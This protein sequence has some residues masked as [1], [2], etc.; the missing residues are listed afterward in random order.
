MYRFVNNNDIVPRVPFAVMW[1]R[2]AGSLYYIN[3]YGN[4]RSATVWQRLKDRLRGYWNAWKK[5]M[6]FDSI[7]DHAMPKYIKRIH[8]FAYYDDEMKSK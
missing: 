6:W 3:T 4:I 7:Y 8:D 1:Y 2:H 5:R